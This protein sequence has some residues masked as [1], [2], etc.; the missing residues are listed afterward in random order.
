MR[1]SRETIYLSL[2]VQTRG[3]LKKELKKHLRSHRTTR[4][5]HGTSRKGQGRGSIQDPVSSRERPAHV[6]DRAIPG[7]WEGDLIA[8]SKNTHVVT[9]VERHLRFTL[10]IK[11]DGKDAPTVTTALTRHIQELPIEL[12]TSLTWDRG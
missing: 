4:R 8:G 1:V 2:F 6:K 12:R 9:L 5:A 7:A 11:V 3:V 10:L